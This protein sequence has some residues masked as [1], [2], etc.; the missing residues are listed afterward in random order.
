MH[1]GGSSP[2]HKLRVMDR[3]VNQ[4]GR[5]S[6]MGSRRTFTRCC[7]IA[8]AAFALGACKDS[9][10]PNQNIEAAE[11]VNREFRYPAYETTPAAA[12]VIPFDNHVWQVT[13]EKQAMPANMLRSVATVNG[14]D[15]FALKSDA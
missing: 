12:K 5:M 1:R 2:G 8:G 13:G 3:P 14:A 6:G 9:G 11:A 4:G 10:L 15:L 7:V